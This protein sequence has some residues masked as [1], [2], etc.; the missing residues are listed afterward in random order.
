[1]FFRALRRLDH[2]GVAFRLALAGANVRSDPREFVEAEE[3]FVD[4]LVH[5]GHL[6][7]ERY[8]ELLVA[9]VGRGEHGGARVLR[10][11]DGRGDGRRPGAA[12]APRAELPGARR[13]RSS[14]TAV[15]YDSYGDLVRRLREVLVDLDRGPAGDRRAAQVDAALRLDRARAA[16]TT[17]RSTPSWRA[18]RPTRCRSDHR[19]GRGPR[20]PLDRRT[21]ARTGCTVVLLPEGT[22]GS[23]RGA[24][25]RAGDPRARRARCRAGSSTGST[26]S[27]LTGGSAFGLAAAD[28]VL[29]WCEEQGHRLPHAGRPGADRPRARPVRPRRSAT[30]RCGPAADGR[31]PRLRDR[32]HGAVPDRRGRRRHRG[33]RRQVARARARAA[34]RARHRDGPPRRPRG[35]ARSSRSTRSAP[36]TRTAPPAPS[37]VSASLDALLRQ[38][39]HRGDRHQRPARQARLPLGRPGRPRRPGPRDRSR[40]TPGPTATPSWPWPPAASTPRSTPSASPPSPPSS[41]RVA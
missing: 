36:S 1:M 22:T 2:D 25:R 15:L 29:R 41:G 8:L 40:P 12:P 7:R 34:G 14:T 26:R 35:R 9:V 13:P 5:V 32:R 17:P 21:V 4:R 28:G 24:G 23:A 33:D 19:R 16:P 6:A 3:R 18:G 31:V 38:H 11:R 37:T 39:H 20:R 27:L 30:G 10:H